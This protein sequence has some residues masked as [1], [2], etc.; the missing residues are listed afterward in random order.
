MHIVSP[1]LRVGE[2]VEVIVL[3]EEWRDRPSIREILGGYEGGRLFKTADEV[4]EYL[5]TERE[6]WDR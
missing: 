2:T 1:E 4:D 3:E 6:S 5:R